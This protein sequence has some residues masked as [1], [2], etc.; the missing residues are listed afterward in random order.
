MQRPSAFRLFDRVLVKNSLKGGASSVRAFQDGVLYS[1]PRIRLKETNLFLKVGQWNGVYVKLPSKFG[2][3]EYLKYAK[4]GVTSEDDLRALEEDERW[5][6]L[7]HALESFPD[8]KQL[9]RLGPERLHYLVIHALQYARLQ[10]QSAVAIP[11]ARF[12]AVRLFRLG[13]FPCAEPAIFQESIRGTT[14]WDMF[15]FDRM[16]IAPRWKP[17]LS[18]ISAQLSALLAS[19]LVNHIDWNIKN[20]VLQAETR[21]LFY[22]DVKPS[23]FVPKH[24]N[25]QNLKGIHD[26]FLD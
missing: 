24:T 20:F 8:L 25:E 12:A 14:L 15:D 5:E 16:R 7:A 19:G 13:L 10:R 11:E 1:L 9:L 17:L 21:R 4:Q 6:R 23:L 18:R 3:A 26:F 2:F 22:V